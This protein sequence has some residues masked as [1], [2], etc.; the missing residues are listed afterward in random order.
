[1]VGM[2]NALE[3]G[4]VSVVRGGK[5]IL[6][7]VDLTVP[8]GQNIA[9]IGPNGSGKTTLIKLF[10]GDIHPYYDEDSPATMRIFGMERWNLFDLRSRMGVVSM[11]LQDSFGPETTVF[12]VICSGFFNSTDVFRDRNISPRMRSAVSSAAATMGMEDMLDATVETL[13]LGEMRRALIARAL[14]TEPDM[15]VLDEP[16][17][18]LDIVMKSRF[19]AMFDIL[20]SAGVS[21]MLVTHDLTDIPKGVDRIVMMK[22]G[23][24]FRDGPKEELLDDS[25]VSELY[26][27]DIKVVCDDGIYRMHVAGSVVE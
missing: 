21:I 24:I 5:L 15:L 17:T 12:E 1:M 13:S 26:G 3:L 6:D 20:V 14:V 2:E 11:D 23:R 9:V 8:R 7:S 19:R 25:T 27:E 10:R 16:M 22:E 4:N 18:G